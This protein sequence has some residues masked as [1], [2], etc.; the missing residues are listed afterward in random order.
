MARFTLQILILS[1]SIMLV[2]SVHDTAF[3][4]QELD[5]YV[6]TLLQNNYK[7][8]ND[9]KAEWEML[10]NELGGLLLDLQ[11]TYPLSALE[12]AGKLNADEIL[13]QV[14]SSEIYV[15]SQGSIELS[16]EQVKLKNI[17]HKKAYMQSKKQEIDQLE[18]ELSQR[19]Y[20]ISYN[21]LHPN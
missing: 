6:R 19:A 21:L 20:I 18:Q 11:T 17:I 16:E 4:P 10:D 14:G 2:M 12:G 3:S 8:L 5:F 7:T 13:H 9:K 1:I 15:N